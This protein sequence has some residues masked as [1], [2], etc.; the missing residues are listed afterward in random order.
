M[1]DLD[2]FKDMKRQ[3]I[4]NDNSFDFEAPEGGSLD[5]SGLKKSEYFF[6]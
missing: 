3:F 1:Y 5:L 4:S 2:I 6:C